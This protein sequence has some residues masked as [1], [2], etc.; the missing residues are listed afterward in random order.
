[1]WRSYISLTNRTSRSHKPHTWQH[2]LKFETLSCDK[3]QKYIDIKANIKNTHKNMSTTPNC[4]HN[5]LSSFL[6]HLFLLNSRVPSKRVAMV[7]KNVF[8][9][10][11][12]PLRAGIW[13]RSSFRRWLESTDERRNKKG[14]HHKYLHIYRQLASSL[15]WMQPHSGAKKPTHPS[16]FSILSFI[17]TL[18]SN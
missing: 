8:W 18:S 1:M 13:Y 17:R 9:G 4:F 5:R 15:Y 11:S 6:L 12:R 7:S 2:S 3:P 10:A 14:N 16:I